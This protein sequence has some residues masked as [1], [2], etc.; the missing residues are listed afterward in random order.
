[1]KIKGANA[2]PKKIVFYEKNTKSKAWHRYA[3]ILIPLISMPTLVYIGYTLHDYVLDP[4]QQRESSNLKVLALA[5]ALIC[6]SFAVFCY[7]CIR[8]NTPVLSFGKKRFRTNFSLTRS[9]SN[10]C[11]M[12]SVNSDLQ[13]MVPF[14]SNHHATYES[15]IF[16]VPPRY[17]VVPEPASHY[18]SHMTLSSST[19]QLKIVE[20]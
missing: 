5:G 20:V 13:F 8:L 6:I 2:I 11:F 12:K 15:I 4:Y 17:T 1:M 7:L 14:N 16:D 18:K 9:T 19:T 10:G 3:D